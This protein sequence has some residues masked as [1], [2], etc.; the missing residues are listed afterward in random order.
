MAKA[1]SKPK[2]GLD[3]CCATI[4]TQGFFGVL[5]LDLRTSQASHVSWFS[6]RDSAKVVELWHLPMLV[7]VLMAAASPSECRRP[8]GKSIIQQSTAG[9]SHRKLR[10][11]AHG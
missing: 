9:Q 10:V 1:T 2:V 4:S 7:T 6:A 11:L 5:Q 3:S 8:R